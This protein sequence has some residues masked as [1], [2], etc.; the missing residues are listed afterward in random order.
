MPG[1]FEFH[2]SG[3]SIHKFAANS[4]GAMSVVMPHGGR[5][6]NGTFDIEARQLLCLDIAADQQVVE[7][8]DAIP[9]VPVGLEH[10][11][12]LPVGASPAMIF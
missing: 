12:M 9:A 5:R 10:D 6:P 1:R 4:D 3:R 2:G 8:A 11:A 7:A